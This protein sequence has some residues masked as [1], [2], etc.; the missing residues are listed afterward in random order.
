MVE[1]IRRAEAS[2]FVKFS[3]ALGDEA[4]FHFTLLPSLRAAMSPQGKHRLKCSLRDKPSGQNMRVTKDRKRVNRIEILIGGGPLRSSTIDNIRFDAINSILLSTFYSTRTTFPNVILPF[5]TNESEDPCF[6]H[7]SYNRILR[8]C[9]NVIPSL[10]HFR[11]MC[12]RTSS[13]TTNIELVG[14]LFD[15][16]LL[17]RGTIES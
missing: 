3:I 4:A 5:E 6:G 9:D 11:D 13:S 14:A 1:G 8:Y 15:E 10:T 17:Q 12:A 16:R 2:R 7:G